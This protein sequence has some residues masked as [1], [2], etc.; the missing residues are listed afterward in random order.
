MLQVL[1]LS[2][3]QKLNGKGEKK[4]LYSSVKNA[5]PPRKADANPKNVQPALKREP[6]RNR[7]KKNLRAA[8]APAK[9]NHLPKAPAR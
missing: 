3:S 5:V 2:N 9:N 6:W 7:E 1:L 4:W 8:A